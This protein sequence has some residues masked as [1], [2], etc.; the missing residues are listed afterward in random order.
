MY[1]AGREPSA[2]KRS[3][4]ARARLHLSKALRLH[5]VSFCGTSSSAA[6][7]GYHIHHQDVFT[8]L[9]ALARQG[10][11]VDVAF[12]D[13]P[14]DW[15]PYRDLLE[16]SFVR[17]LI[18]D[19]GRAVIEH[20]RKAS[21]PDSGEGYQRSRIVRQGDHCLSFYEHAI[22]VRRDGE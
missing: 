1:L 17:R 19:H 11:R 16:I 4:V 9:R 6:L 2:L 3:A 21:L 22:G 14:Y 5:N 18:S 10:L 20:D 13:P 15:K 12:F 7:S 8:A